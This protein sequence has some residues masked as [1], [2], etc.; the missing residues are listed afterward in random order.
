MQ[1]SVALMVAT[2]LDCYDTPV[3][4]IVLL[5]AAASCEGHVAEVLQGATPG[6]HWSLH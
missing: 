4:G 1:G 3:C 5:Q 6:L 2:Y